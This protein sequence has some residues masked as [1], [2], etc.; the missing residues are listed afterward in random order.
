MLGWHAPAKSGRTRPTV[1]AGRDDLV[2]APQPPPSPGDLGWRIGPGQ[3]RATG[4][5]EGGQADRVR[6]ARRG[7][8]RGR[9]RVHWFAG[10]HRAG[11]GHHGGLLI[12][13]SSQKAAPGT[14]VGR[15]LTWF[16]RAVGHLPWSRQVIKAH[17]DPGW[18]AQ[19]GPAQ[20]SSV[21]EQALAAEGASLS[22]SGASLTGLLWQDPARDP[23]SL[24]AVAAF[25]GVKFAVNISVD[26]AGR[27]GTLC[28][29]RIGLRRPAGLRSTGNLPGWPPTPACWPRGCHPAGGVPRCT[30]WLPRP[31]GR[32]P[33]CSSCSSSARSRTRSPRGGSPGTRN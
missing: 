28:S 5:E 6:L 18:L 12:P 29:G 13:C 4:L 24:L 2:L 9:G 10:Q 8:C 31:P 19:G 33:R 11:P 14:P 1:R 17:F 23:V 27:I 20:L 26:R 7:A 32:W 3:C 16:L 30:R 21:V 15:Q 22:S 25:S